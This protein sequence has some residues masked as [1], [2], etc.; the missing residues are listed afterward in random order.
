M[1]RKNIVGI[2]AVFRQ[3]PKR[4]TIQNLELLRF[5]PYCGRIQRKVQIDNFNTR[6]KQRQSITDYDK[7]V[8]IKY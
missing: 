1:L 8:T 5:L 2:D 4:A 7:I 3:I 6:N